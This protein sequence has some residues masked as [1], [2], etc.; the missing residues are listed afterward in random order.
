MSSAADWP[1]SQIGVRTAPGSTTTVRIL[2]SANSWRIDSAIAS[3]ACFEAEYGAMN[4]EETRPPIDPMNTI[5][6]R[7]PER[8]ID[9]SIALVTATCP[10]HLEL[11]P[12]LLD[13]E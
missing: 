8:R 11:A 10:I 5:R 13:G 7:D 9:G 12:P 3:I 6:P 2:E 4:G 1:F